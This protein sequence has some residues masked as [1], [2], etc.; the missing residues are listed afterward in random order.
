M[1]IYTLWFIIVGGFFLT[2]LIFCSILRLRYNSKKDNRL[3]QRTYAKMETYLL[4][5]LADEILPHQ[6]AI[7][8]RP[9]ELGYLQDFLLPYLVSLKG[10]SFEKLVAVAHRSGLVKHLLQEGRSTEAWKQAQAIYFLGL[11]REPQVL[12]LLKRGLASSN[13]FWFY[14]SIIALAR[15]DLENLPRVLETLRNRSDWTE[16]LG[17]S[18]FAEMGEKVCPALIATLAQGETSPR[19]K[20]LALA[21][22]THYGYLG[23]EETLKEYILHSTVRELRIRALRAWSQMQLG[24]FEGISAAMEDPDW[25]VRVAAV[26]ALSSSGTADHAHLARP[27]LRDGNW[28]VRLR[29]AQTMLKLS[30]REDLHTILNNPLEDRYAKDMLRYILTSEGGATCAI[31]NS[32]IL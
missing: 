25:E 3:R 29:A 22:L 6:W 24:F 12:P 23:A 9:H 16:H 30:A 19:I 27:L 20:G 4:S 13:M 15:H 32:H 28:W 11:I 2:S 18:I 1:M 31:P 17:I 5:L 26:T 10:E 21:V 14:P 7:R 8:V